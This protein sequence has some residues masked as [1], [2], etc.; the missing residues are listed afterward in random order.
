MHPCKL[1]EGILS[2]CF[3]LSA[4]EANGLASDTVNWLVFME[5]LSALQTVDISLLNETEKVA[6]LLNLYHLMV[7]HG[8]LII[9]PP[10]SWSSWQSFFNTVTYSLSF[11]IVSI[12]ELEHNMLRAAMSRPSPLLS[13]ITAP[14][15][16]FPNMCLTQG[17][18]RLNFCINNG[19]RSLPKYVPIYKPESLDR[20]L[21]EMT[22]MT[23]AETVEIDTSRK[24]VI[25]PKV[26]SWFLNDFVPR[27]P[28]T[29]PPA[30]ADCL[31]V[32]ANYLRGNNH[33]II[34]IPISINL[35]IN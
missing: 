30:P 7:L 3:T 11:D 33:F 13:K 12:A 34:I 28:F 15:S 23:L 9:G 5:E 21:D 14:N 27:K 4:L 22:S 2:K 32:A 6:F 18:F 20:Q 1:V 10:P 26:C 16:E 25:L 19:S 8:S 29:G 24:T 17:D 35:I 31:R